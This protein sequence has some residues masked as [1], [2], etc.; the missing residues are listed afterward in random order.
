MSAAIA[1]PR[2]V[3]LATVRS[4]FAEDRADTEARLIS[5]F[6]LDLNETR[7]TL[8][9]LAVKL[10]GPQEGPRSVV[11]IGPPFPDEE[12]TSE[13]LGLCKLRVPILRQSAARA[14]RVRALRAAAEKRRVKPLREL[15]A[16]HDPLFLRLKRALRIAPPPTPEELAQR[17]Q[18]RQEMEERLA[19]I[20]RRVERALAEPPTWAWEGPAAAFHDE[21]SGARVTGETASLFILA[22]PRVRSTTDLFRVLAARRAPVI[23]VLAEA[24][25]LPED[26]ALRIQ[27]MGGCVLRL[28]KRWHS[29]RTE[30]A[31]SAR[32]GMTVG[33]EVEE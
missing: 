14:G 27:A 24:V 2:Q 33:V 8:L 16:L 25:H 11:A 6:L 23:V 15:A 13:T 10:L 18:T 17:E 5:R 28:G 31:T 9:D 1:P 26:A 29:W 30:Q 3:E 22:A 12:F 7:G 20:E 4:T 32:Y 19:V 21:V